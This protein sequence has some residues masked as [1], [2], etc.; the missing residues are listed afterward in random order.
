VIVLVLAI[1]QLDPKRRWAIPRVLTCALAAGLAADLVK[2]LI[3]R[4]RPYDGSLVGSVWTTFGPWFPLWGAG[5][6]GQSFPSAHTATAVGFAAA[7]CWLYPQGRWLFSIL[8]ALVGCQRIVCGAHFPSDVLVGAATGY[9]ASLFLLKIG[10]ASA[11]FDRK[12]TIW[13]A[14]W[15]GSVADPEPVDR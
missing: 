2:L 4:T 5:S 3:F 10:P 9:T 1:H 8:A 15:G 13:R 6:S 14:G 12:E 7:L 11:W